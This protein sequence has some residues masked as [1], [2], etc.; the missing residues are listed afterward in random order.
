MYRHTLAKTDKRS[1]DG[2][3]DGRRDGASEEWIATDRQIN[4]VLAYY[5]QHAAAR[6]DFWNLPCLLQP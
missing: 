6:R 2:W 1:F 3:L 4:C 5:R